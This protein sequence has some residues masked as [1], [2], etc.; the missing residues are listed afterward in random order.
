MES[1]KVV[2]GTTSQETAEAPYVVNTIPRP[3]TARNV[4]ETPMGLRKLGE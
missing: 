4:I 1:K 2:D 3:K